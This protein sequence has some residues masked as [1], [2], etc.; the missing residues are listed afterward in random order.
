MDEPL[1]IAVIGCG[2]A[3]A[4]AALLLDRAGHEVTVFERVPE[5]GPVGAGIMMQPSGLLV[6][7]RLGLAG[8]V[9]A[10]GAHVTRLFC[11]TTHGRTILDLRYE[12]LAE[13]LFG[14]GLHRGVLFETLFD[15][16]RASNVRVRCGV[17]VERLCPA[18]RD[19][20]A[21]ATAEGTTEGV[22]DLA[23]VCD[24][25][26]SRVRD[27]MVGLTKTVRPYPWGALWFIGAD[28]DARHGG[29]LHQIVAGTERMVGLLPT[30]LG[31]GSAPSRRP[32]VSLFVSTRAA[33]VS[34]IQERGLTR[35]KEEVAE[36][37]PDSAAVL[38]QI[39]DFGEL[40]FASY[41]D[42]T[43]P[44]WHAHRIAL[45]GDAAH[46]TSPQLGQGCNLALCDAA[47][48]ADALAAER[49]V[50]RALERYTASRREHL[51]YYQLATRWLTPFFQSD[52]GLLGVLRD[53]ALGPASSLAFVR[54]EMVRR[55]A[56]TKTGILVGSRETRMPRATVKA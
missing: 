39:V 8:R 10:S 54:R 25:A 30:G 51:A 14:V 24:G 50:P 3:G 18:P 16:L 33:D 2:T 17:A 38:D 13:G 20:I 36:T 6:L 37:A 42:V 41:Y 29:R 27:S 22:F 35:W 44:R 15:A 5:P 19:R 1:R 7:E 31:A 43:L 23:L 4:A 45:L 9:L 11:E 40:T 56:G 52:R 53:A 49:T 26:R 12:D 46:A 28:P 47:A 32:L 48:F 34:A 55:M 21:P